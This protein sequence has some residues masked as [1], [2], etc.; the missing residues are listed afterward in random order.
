[1][2]EWL[3]DGITKGQVHDEYGSRVLK[4]EVPPSLAVGM[5]VVERRTRNRE[6]LKKEAAKMLHE[7]P[8]QHDAHLSEA[9]TLKVLTNYLISKPFYGKCAEANDVGQHTPTWI[10]CD[11]ASEKAVWSDVQI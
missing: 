10:I 4:L 8:W 3:A 5:D 9:H 7:Q 1:V 6:K 2:Q 11:K